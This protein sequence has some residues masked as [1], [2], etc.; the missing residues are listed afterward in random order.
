MRGREGEQ[1]G[2]EAKR[3]EEGREGGRERG[4]HRL[5]LITSHE[6]RDRI[7]TPLSASLYTGG[8]ATNMSDI[9]NQNLGKGLLISEVQF[10]WTGSSK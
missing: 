7:T 5:I 2:K 10:G 6:L 3:E 4:L 1:E 9:Y 8:Y